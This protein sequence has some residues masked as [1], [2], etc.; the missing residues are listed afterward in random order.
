MPSAAV[1]DSQ[2]VKTTEAG[3]SN[4]YDAGKKI[5]GRKRHAMVDTDGR[6][7]ELLIRTADVQ[8]R[9]GASSSLPSP[10]STAIAASSNTLSRA[11]NRQQPS[12]AASAMMLISAWLVTHEIRGRA[13]SLGRS[14][15]AGVKRASQER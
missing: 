5:K 2:S 9:A 1:I 4:G 12:S 6:A 15:L 8:D 13:L 10:G 3:G 7:L 11:S 14:A